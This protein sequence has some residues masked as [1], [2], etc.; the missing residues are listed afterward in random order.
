MVPLLIGGIMGFSPAVA[1]PQLH[2][3]GRAAV[4][5]SAEGAERKFA[6]APNL[7]DLGDE[8]VTAR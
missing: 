6:R 5:A 4:F 1:P 3:A 8:K 7:L 2:T